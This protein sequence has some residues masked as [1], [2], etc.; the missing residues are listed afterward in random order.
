MNLLDQLTHGRLLVG[1]GS[2]TTPEETIG[3]GVKFQDSRQVLD[4]NIGIAMRLW[5][6]QMVDDPVEFDTGHYRG[7]VVQRI[8]PRSFRQ[9]YPLMMGV[10]LR[11]SSIQRAVHYGWS[12]FIPDFVP[13]FPEDNAPSPKFLESLNTY[14]DALL[15]SSHPESVIEECLQWTTHTYQCVH[16]AETDAQARREL[17][18]IVD[19]YQQAIDRERPYNKRAEKISGVDLHAAPDARSENWI[20]AWCLYGSPE[21]VTAELQRYAEAGVGN[22]LLSFTNGPFTDERWRLSQQSIQLFAAEVMPRLRGQTARGAA[23]VGEQRF[24]S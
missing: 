16:L 13:P 10:A 15:Q 23:P 3:F 5:A 6:K 18:F 19:Q 14:R 9:P 12:A 1:I 24:G 7:A 11:D 20:K 17:E 4:E 21:T 22:V 2:G 8:V